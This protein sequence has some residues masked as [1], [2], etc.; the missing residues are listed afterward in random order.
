M[1]AEIEDYLSTFIK[2]CNSL[3]IP[4]NST[5]VI[6]EAMKLD[7]SL[8]EYTYSS[9]HKCFYRF[10]YRNGFSICKITHIGQSLKYNSKEQLQKFFKL[11][12]EIRYKSNIMD[13]LDLFA[14]MDE[15]PICYENIYSTTITTIV[16]QTV[17]VKNFNKDKLLITVILLSEGTK[18]EANLY[19]KNKMLSKYTWKNIIRK[20]I[21]TQ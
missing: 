9:L 19:Y 8:K 5:E 3:E 16:T 10:I 12:Y 13:Q 7:E 21:I 6:N 18:L 20:K 1:T 4:I 17:S 2:H 11:L 14:N 15:T